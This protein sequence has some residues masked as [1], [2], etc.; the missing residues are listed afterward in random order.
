MMNWFKKL[1]KRKSRDKH[2]AKLDKICRQNA[3][4]KYDIHK[5]LDDICIKHH[6]QLPYEPD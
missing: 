1:V 4:A 3:A 5:R 6:G 2:I